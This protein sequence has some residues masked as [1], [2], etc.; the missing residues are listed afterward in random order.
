MSSIFTLSGAFAIVA[1]FLS[2]GQVL[3]ESIES[4]NISFDNIHRNLNAKNY[5]NPSDPFRTS[6][7]YLNRR[8]AFAI[9]RIILTFDILFTRR[10]VLADRTLDFSIKCFHWSILLSEGTSYWPISDLHTRN[11]KHHYSELHVLVQA[12]S[13][14]TWWN[15][16]DFGGVR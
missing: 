4:S 3:G 9:A 2:Y 15:C 10:S 5:S 16:D 7:D 1:T 6:M 8:V 13:D 12:S 11:L 14:M